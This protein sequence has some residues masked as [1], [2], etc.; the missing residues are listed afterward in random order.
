MPN[1]VSADF[2]ELASGFL[3]VEAPRAAPDGSLWFSDLS[4][5]TVHRRDVNGTVRT[6]LA[7]RDWVGGIVHDVSGKTLCG[8]RGGII[9]LDLLTGDT[10]SVLSEIEGEPIVAVNDMEADGAGGFYGGTI[11]FVSIMELGRRPAPG[12]FFHMDASGKITVIRRDVFASNGIAFSPCGRWLY[13]S[14]TSR[15]VW[16][17]P[18]HD[19]VAGQPELFIPLEDS[20]GLVTDQDG[21]LWVACWESGVLRRFSADGQPTHSLKS[22]APHIV[23]V[24]VM[25]G[26]PPSL[27]VTTGGN[28][29]MP[30]AGALLRLPVD[31]PGVPDHLTALTMLETE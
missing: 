29:D 8:G 18:R 4:A 16:R 27:L 26:T 25:P 23:S 30:G 31:S 2:E 13:H 15:G 20:D 6:T 22:P 12:R 11:D 28:A 14:E 19:G 24:A 5:G 9:A 10:Q 21:G 17:Y 3:F 1:P 7:G